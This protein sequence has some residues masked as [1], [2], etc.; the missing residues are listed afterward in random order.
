MSQAVCCWCRGPLV[1]AEGAWWCSQVPCQGRQAAWA[2]EAT[3]K[4]GGRSLLYV[5]TPRQ[6][7]FYETTRKVRRVLYGG[8]AGPGKSHALRWGLYRDCMTIPNLNCLL[9]RRTYQQL[10]QTH[11]MEMLREDK[12]IGAKYTTGDKVM[13]FSNGSVIRAGHCENVADAQNYLSTE[14]DRIAF[15]ELVTFDRDMALEIMSRART[16]KAAVKAAGDAQVWAGTNPGGRG[17]LWVKEFFIERTVDR[18]EFPSYTPDRYGFVE[19]TLND[20]PYI[21]DQYRRDLEDLPEMRKRQLLYGDWNAFEGQFFS[22]WRAGVHVAEVAI[23]PKVEH[24]AGMDWGYNAPGCV[25]WFA[26]LPDGKLHVRWEYKFK[27]LSA[28]AV[29]TEIKQ[30][31]KTLGI[32]RLRYLA[33]DPAMKQKTGAGRGE[34]IFETLLRRG[35]PMRTSDNDRFNGWNRVHE[36]LRL[37]AQDQ[38]HLT[39]S[40]ECKYLARTLPALVQDDHDPEDV[41]SAKDDHAADALRYGVM[42]RP[43]PTRFVADTEP[44]V[45]SLAWWKRHYEGQSGTG[46]LA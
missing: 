33:C 13:R 27:G 19:A 14:Y 32:Q 11:L 41:D 1:Q 21:S 26:A 35:L 30:I 12:L 36:W 25:L 43:G 8:Q 38:P 4:R 44:T 29:A 2:I 9:L 23:A 24:F 15:D 6:V 31:T 17:A 40:P 3:A 7:D 28:E 5:P 37:D 16:S 34:S 22:E 39:V 20:N 46:V 45:N 42:S 10:E 18:A